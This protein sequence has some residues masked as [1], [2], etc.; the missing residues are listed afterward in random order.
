M[1]FQLRGPLVYRWI[2]LWDLLYASALVTLRRWKGQ[3]LLDNW[4][5]DFEVANLFS[6]RHMTRAMSMNELAQA[7][8]LLDSIEF[9]S[10]LPLRVRLEASTLPGV[11]GHWHLPE[12]AVPDRTLLYLHGGGYAFFA[13]AH[14]QM[15]N[16]IACATRSGVFA[17]DYRLAPENPYPAQLDDALAAYQA[18]LNAG[19]R[20]RQIVVAGDSAG[21]HL[22]LSLVKTLRDLHLPMPAL[23]VGLCPWTEIGGATPCASENDPYDWVQSGMTAQFARWFTAGQAHDPKAISPMAFDVSGFPPLYLQAGDKEALADMIVRF[24]DHV[25]AGGEEVVLDVWSGM[26]HDF[27]AYG[28]LLDESRAALRRLADAVDHYLD[29]ARGTPLCAS[30][31]TVRRSGRAVVERRQ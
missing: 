26:T 25:A 17:L 12:N 22:A 14:Q 7:R 3:K 24:A 2:S 27:Q 6:R 8:E 16:H 31:Y 9:D 4:S 23:A 15:I 13:R 21:G 11:S 1:S 20:S 5:W 18:L 30:K 19:H 10:P 29:D 28:D